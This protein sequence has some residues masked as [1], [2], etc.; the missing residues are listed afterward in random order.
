MGPAIAA[1]ISV[2]WLAAQAAAPSAGSAAAGKA[3]FDGAGG[4]AR[5]HSLDEPSRSFGSDLSWIGILRTPAALRKSIVDPGDQ[6]FRR[7][8]AVVV[9]TKAGQ[10]FEGLAQTEDDRSIQVRSVDGESRTFLKSDLQSLERQER[11]LMPSYAAKLSTAQIDD[12]VAYLRTLRAIPPVEASDR[13]RTVGTLTETIDFFDRPTR[14]AD[15]RS[16]DI[17]DALEIQRGA[18]V[19]DVGAGTGYFTWRLARQVGPAG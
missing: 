10:H 4:C 17:V 19:A 14:N 13:T 2:V 3:L 18:T 11:S 7:Y 9:E 15:E 6:V 8:Y 1:L 5:C 16:D 12:L